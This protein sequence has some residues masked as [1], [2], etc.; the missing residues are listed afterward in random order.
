MEDWAFCMWAGARHKMVS[1]PDMPSEDESIRMYRFIHEL[2]SC[3]PDPEYGSYLGKLLK[4]V[5]L[6]P[7]LEESF[8]GSNYKSYKHRYYVGFMPAAQKPVQA[9][10]AT[11][12]SRVAWMPVEEARRRMRPYN[13]EKLRVLN[14]VDQVLRDYRIYRQMV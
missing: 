14:R 12:V 5:P 2:P 10:Q 1:Y 9:E 11:E 6:G 4:A 13:Q 8:T 7:S 3:C